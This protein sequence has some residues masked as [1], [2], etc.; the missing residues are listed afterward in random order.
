MA[1]EAYLGLARIHYE[2]DDL[3]AAERYGQQCAQLTQQMESVSTIASYKVF[4]TRLKCAH[5]DAP[6]AAADL[7]EAEEF[8]RRQNFMFMMPEVAAAQVLILLQQGNLA[9][10]THLAQT[11]ELP[12]SQARVHLA[13]GDTSSALTVLES[14]RQQVEA[15]G[16]QDEQ[17]RVMVLQAIALYTQRKIDN[18]WQVLADALTL[19][20]PGGFIRIFVDEGTPMAN[21]LSEAAAYGMMPDYVG[22]LLAVFEA[23]RKSGDKPYR[24]P[25]Q[26]LID[27]LSQR[28]LEVLRLIAQGLSNREISQ[29]LFLALSTVKGHNRVIFDKLQVQRRTE[30]IACAHELGLI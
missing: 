25:A 21:L 1:C 30:A 5:G 23:Q 29:R 26:S 14:F 24:S 4:L 13:Q 8:V 16:W 17:L 12:L 20:E 19:A 27:P 2:W 22:K 7:Q 11:H 3:D 15:K 9:A 10:A 28:E 18:A 6:G